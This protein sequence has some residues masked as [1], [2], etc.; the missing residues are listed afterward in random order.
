MELLKRKVYKLMKAYKS[1]GIGSD[2]TPKSRAKY[3][4]AFLETQVDEENVDD[5]I[6]VEDDY[7]REML[8]IPNS[9]Q[10]KAQSVKLIE[11]IK[12]RE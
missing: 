7:E 6:P 5:K 10:M 1:L 12:K 11:D 9:H 4:A 2:I 8:K 3:H